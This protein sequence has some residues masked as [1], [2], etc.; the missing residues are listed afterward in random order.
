[1]GG[2]YNTP[3]ESSGGWPEHTVP[4]PADPVSQRQKGGPTSGDNAPDAADLLLKEGVGSGKRK[5]EV[6]PEG[7][8]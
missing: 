6:S 5:D 4:N 8:V 2:G 3:C 1:M 7:G